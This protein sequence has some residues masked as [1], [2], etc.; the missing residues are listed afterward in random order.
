MRLDRS[1]R[2]FILMITDSAPYLALQ[3]APGMREVTNRLHTSIRR[4]GSGIT[5]SEQMAA[6]AFIGSMALCAKVM[7]TIAPSISITSGEGLIDPMMQEFEECVKEMNSKRGMKLDDISLT[8]IWTTST[9]KVQARINRV[10]DKLR[11]EAMDAELPRGRAA[12][13]L[14]ANDPYT[15]EESVIRQQALSNKNYT[16]SAYLTA[17][18]MHP[19]NHMSDM[20]FRI[21]FYTRHMFPLKMSRDYCI[22]S[23]KMDKLC[24]H[25]M[26]C[27]LA[28]VRAL[29]R[30]WA[31]AGLGDVLRRVAEPRAAAVGLKPYRKTLEPKLRQFFAFN[32]KASKVSV[33]QLKE[34]NEHQG[35][36]VEKRADVGLMDENGGRHIC[37]DVTFAAGRN[38][39]AQKAQKNGVKS[40]AAATLA[41]KGKAK[42]YAKLFD[43]NNKPSDDMGEWQGAEMWFFGVDTAGGLGEEAM[44]VVNEMAS[45]N[46]V[47]D[48]VDKQRILEQIS[49]KVQTLRA[50]QIID[51][52]NRFSTDEK[53]T[54]P[55][56]SGTLPVLPPPT[57]KP[58]SG[59]ED[60]LSCD[61][62]TQDLSVQD[63]DAEDDL[64]SVGSA[65]S[66]GFNTISGAT[67]LQTQD[68]NDS[69]P[70]LFF[71]ALL[72]SFLNAILLSGD[73]IGTQVPSS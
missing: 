56:V 72:L 49:V 39:A 57:F 50:Q 32:S 12:S 35:I 51:T 7:G 4:G 6:G 22:C 11:E 9:E 55:F 36:H 47:D 33:S 5:S 58:L 63:S 44:N 42:A 2:S 60:L 31:H 52:I 27:K 15:E 45:W 23:E 68:K 53:P 1:L 28:A 13:G 54:F 21:A 40:G 70:V 46:E 38:K 29:L 3:G 43:I 25:P 69:L 59:Y 62:A 18:P 17:N 64:M 26:C 48:A 37:I 41:E 34:L 71:S 24:E 73:E 65:C 61:F 20:A 16:A 67:E 19:E 8:S 10:L 14:G 66:E 30:N